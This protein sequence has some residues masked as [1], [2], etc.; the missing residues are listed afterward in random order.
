L[1]AELHDAPGCLGWDLRLSE[2]DDPAIGMVSG[3]KGAP[4][5][6]PHAKRCYGER[7]AVLQQQPATSRVLR[8][9]GFVP[10]AGEVRPAA[11]PIPPAGQASTKIHHVVFITKENRTFDEVFGDIGSLHG[12]VVNGEA[13]L[14][15]YGERATVSRKDAPTL[16]HVAVTPNHHALA[17]QFALSDNFYVDSDVSTDGQRWLQGIYPN[18]LTETIWPADYGS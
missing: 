4:E 18:E 7:A 10:A 16:N 1:D 6:Y 13:D 8:N 15:R 14:V 9:N 11:F 12:E 17:R 5:V 3:R 2:P